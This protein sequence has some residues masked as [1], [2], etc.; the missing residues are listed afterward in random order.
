MLQ[1]TEYVLPEPSRDALLSV[2]YKY[3]FGEI[4]GAVAF[5]RNLKPVEKDIKIEGA[6]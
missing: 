5:L 1:V 3:P 4:E 2:L 6:E